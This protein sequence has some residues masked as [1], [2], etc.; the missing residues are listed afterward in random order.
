MNWIP[1]NHPFPMGTFKELWMD[2]RSFFQKTVGAVVIA[3]IAG[4]VTLDGKEFDATQL[5]LSG[6]PGDK[7]SLILYKAMDFAMDNPGSNVLLVYPSHDSTFFP[8]TRDFKLTDGGNFKF[9]ASRDMFT[10]DNGS[11]LYLGTIGNIKKFRFFI[12]SAVYAHEIDKKSR[13]FAFSRAC[14]GPRLMEWTEA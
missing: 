2:R 8:Y 3:T 5:K 4:K 1:I 14:F 11:H 13:E 9:I 7:S 12:F 10:F 6:I